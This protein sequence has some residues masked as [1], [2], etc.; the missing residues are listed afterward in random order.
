MP[1]FDSA[2]RMTAMPTHED[3][4]IIHMEFSKR[5]SKEDTRLG[6]FFKIWGK[7]FMEFGSTVTM[8]VNGTQNTELENYEMKDGD[9]IE[10]RYEN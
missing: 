7:G 2:M 3:M 8:S 6:N 1:T 9:K 4:P 10:L 5:V